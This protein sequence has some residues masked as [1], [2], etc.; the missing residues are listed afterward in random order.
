MPHTGSVTTALVLL[1]VFS[2][3]VS[4]SFIPVA[5][6]PYYRIWMILFARATMLYS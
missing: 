4:D 3:A 5:A 2:G 1:V 6:L